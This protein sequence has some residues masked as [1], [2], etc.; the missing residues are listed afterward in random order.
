[1]SQG[2]EHTGRV[3]AGYR[4]LH[5]LGMGG[6]SE[7]YLAQRVQ[8][9]TALV[10][11]KVLLPAWQL[12]PELR[13]NFYVRFRREVPLMQRLEHPH[14]LPVLGYGE[15]VDLV[16]MVLPFMPGGTLAT[17]LA[18]FP[19]GLPLSEAA[20]LL[21]QMAEAVDYAHQHGV[22]HRDLKPTNVL[23][24]AH[25]QLF[26]SDFGIARLLPVGDGTTRLADG[27]APLTLTATGQVLG[28]PIYMA[29]E[30]IGGAR[31]GPAVDLYAL[32]IVLYQMVTGA[33]P[34][35]AETP[36][37]LAIQHAQEPPPPPAGKRCDLPAPAAAAIVRALAK[38][39]DERFASALALA[40][41]FRAG[42][43]GEWTEGL[44]PDVSAPPTLAATPPLPATIA[45]TPPSPRTNVT[46]PSPQPPEAML[47]SPYPPDA[48][49]PYGPEAV[50]PY[51]PDAVTPHT[52]AVPYP[53]R[54]DLAP[55]R[56]RFGAWAAILAPLV[57]VALAAVLLGK[58]FSPSPGGGVSQVAA[59]SGT[60][61]GATSAPMTTS[62]ST[63][64]PTASRA[65]TVAS[66]VAPTHA[67]T[68]APTLARAVAPTVAPKVPP[69]ITTLPPSPSVD[70]LAAC[71]AINGFATA[72]PA[73]PLATQFLSGPSTSFP[74]QSIGYVSRVFDDPSVNRPNVVDHFELLTTCSP[75]ATVGSVRAYFAAQMPQA[76]W[77][78]SS[79]FPYGGNGN[80]QCG[81]SYCWQR[82]QVVGKSQF[83]SLESVSQVGTVTTYQMRL[84]V[85]Q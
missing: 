85:E 74:S 28:T 11:I 23:R 70:P 73:G 41:A 30:Q 12:A 39:P 62:A 55:A 5:V 44:T 78:Q 76:S 15:A 75:S 77:S 65:S 6:A 31:V 43:R 25:G 66:T 24:D 38:H 51:P 52:P 3:L 37:G 56:R 21:E 64:A 79:T 17:Y 46:A 9:P 61:P 57:V 36:L 82:M 84:G 35:Q 72:G 60:Q 2:G 14:I 54:A 19:H 83:A 20:D 10:A 45:V 22:I 80:S 18:N 29:P 63:P 27:Q 1:M 13:A 16:Y 81:D 53:L 59:S 33:V 69:P 47:A 67:P 58:H 71:H 49:P 32:G 40:R 8:D 48:A 68:A 50:T 42:V 4:L 26:L 7:V 34:F